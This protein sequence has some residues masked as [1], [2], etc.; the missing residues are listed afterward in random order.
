MPSSKTMKR[1]LMNWTAMAAALGSIACSV[2]CLRAAEPD[3][4]GIDVVQVR[5][6]FYMLGG[7]GGNIAVQIGSD[8][9]VLVNA[10]TEAA[11]DQVLAALRKLTPLPIRYVIDTN[12]EADFV[13]GNAKLAKAGQTIFINLLGGGGLAAATS[14]GGAAAILAHD[15]ILQRM[16]APSGKVSPFPVDDW[17]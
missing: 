14:N 5:P 4:G 2:A 13:G 17:P 6:N 1:I 12:A 3:T 8:G 10:G 11:S 9:V 15:S 7:A 16:S